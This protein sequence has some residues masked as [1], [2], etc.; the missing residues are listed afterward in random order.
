[1]WSTPSSTARRSTA[2]PT[3]GSR[4]GPPIPSL[5]GRRM[6]PKPSLLTSRSPPMRNLL[7]MASS[8][9]GPVSADEPVACCCHRHNGCMAQVVMLRSDLELWARIRPL[10]ESDDTEWVNVARDLDTWP[11]AREAAR[12]TMRREGAVRA[13]KL[14][15]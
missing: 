2:R 8:L 7:L 14:Y 4:A 10:A 12:L 9:Q 1:M 11:G 3:S 6:A 5:E 15:S 13:R